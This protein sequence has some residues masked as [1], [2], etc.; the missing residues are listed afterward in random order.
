[1]ESC[2]EWTTFESDT[3]TIIA[4]DSAYQIPLRFMTGACP[5]LLETKIE[6]Q[7]DTH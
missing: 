3:A 2:A 6:T 1:M 7:L 4:E 5:Q